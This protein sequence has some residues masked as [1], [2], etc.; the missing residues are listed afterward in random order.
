[1]LK[2]IAIFIIVSHVITSFYATSEVLA[3]S[4]QQ[5][6]E[7]NQIK[8]ASDAKLTGEELIKKL[9]KS[10]KL[11]DPLLLLVNGQNPLSD[12]FQVELTVDPNSGLE[13]GAELAEPF[14]QLLTVASQAGFDFQL[15]SGYRSA[16]TQEYNRQA[17]INS[18]LNE[19]YSQAD[20]EAMTNQ[21]YAPAN[22][23][24]HTT[25]MALDVLGNEWIASGGGLSVSYSQTESAQWLKDHAHEFGFIIR[26]LEGKSE[27]TGYQYEPWHL[28]YV[29]K[30]N[31]AF[32]HQYG[33][34]LEEYISLLTK[35][36]AKP[37]S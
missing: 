27:I 16:S 37:T 21:F 3:A 32:M 36:A 17:A 1:M 2:R 25:G 31:A 23:S 10:A 14:N 12:D 19:G 24:E 29:G 20:A 8:A 9:P 13:Y 5:L 33:I 26:Y 6:P 11:E 18:Y 34:T 22:A 7:V 4:Y 35:R 30:E 15:V 28:R